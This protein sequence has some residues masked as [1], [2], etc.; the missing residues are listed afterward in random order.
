[1]YRKI[2]LHYLFLCMAVFLSWD[3]AHAK[4]SLTLDSFK[5]GSRFMV[6]D[7]DE[8]RFRE[9]NYVTDNYSGGLE[10]LML[11]GNIKDAILSIEAH[12]LYDGDYGLNLDLAKEDSYFLKL[13]TRLTRRYYD[14]SNEPWDPAS[15][16]LGRETA[17]KKD[18]HTYT[19]RFDT[20]VEY[21]IKMD[22]LPYVTIGYTRWSRN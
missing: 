17:E 18:N 21:G 14:G 3:V 16:G 9:D 15:Y 4:S 2:I 6:I 20:D 5:I 1:M 10:E 11:S 8:G 7:G 19:D 13:N 12:A 22:I